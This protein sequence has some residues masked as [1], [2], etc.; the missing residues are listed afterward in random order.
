MQA[1]VYINRENLICFRSLE[2]IDVDNP[3]FFID[4]A[5]FM[6]WY[7]KFDTEDDYSML[8]VFRAFQK[9]QLRTYDITIFCESIG[10]DLPRF[11]ARVGLTKPGRN[12]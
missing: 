7:S 12:I 9:Y 4:N 5:H 11:L 10:F 6:E 3:G 2:S 8:Q 1:Y